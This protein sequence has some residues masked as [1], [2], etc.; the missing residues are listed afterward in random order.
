[1]LTKKKA[2]KAAVFF[3]S[4]LCSTSTLLSRSVCERKVNFLVWWEKN[5]SATKLK[6][7]EK[8]IY[9]NSLRHKRSEWERQ[10]NK[11]KKKLY[12]SK[13]GNFLQWLQTLHLFCRGFFLSFFLCSPK[14][15]LS[16]L[17]LSL[18]VAMLFL[19]HVIHDH[20]LNVFFVFLFF[21]ISLY[22]FCYCWLSIKFFVFLCFR[23]WLPMSLT[24]QRCNIIIVECSDD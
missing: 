14:D 2:S 8:K 18:I 9:T 1:M 5:N 12:N 11:I 3:L 10:T 23:K 15:L 4:K 13:V 20:F 22:I 21:I 7:L 24:F 16:S 6:N 19:P 17:S